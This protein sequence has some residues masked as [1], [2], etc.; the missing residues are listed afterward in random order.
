MEKEFDIKGYVE[1]EF[2]FLSEER[3]NTIV[4]LYIIGKSHGGMETKNRDG[5]KQKMR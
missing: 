2:P 1:Q 4:S 5:K 3:K